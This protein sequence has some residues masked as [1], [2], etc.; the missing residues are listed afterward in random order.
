M[1]GIDRGGACQAAPLQTCSQAAEAAINLTD[2]PMRKAVLATLAASAVLAAAMAPAAAQ[3]ERIGVRAGDIM[4]RGRLLGVFPL[5]TDSDISV[6]GGSVDA[7]NTATPELDFTYF[8]TDNIAF[9]LI[10]ATTI[11]HI[12]ARDVPGAGDISV[13]N[14]FLLPPSLTA[15]WHFSP[16]SRIDP[17]VGAGINYTFFYGAT[18]AGNPVYNVTYDNNVGA[19]VQAGVNYNF[20]GPWFL[21]FDVK[22]IFLS[23][24]AHI[25]D[26][27]IEANVDLNPLIIGAGIGVRF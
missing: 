16:H 20:D 12:T 15:Q 21:N 9:E 26:G 3:E 23:T 4:I 25:N 22:Q 8:V 19:V 17:Y 13:G 1:K 14:V 10:A 2:T 7:S 5:T 24:T 11:H 27:Q 6:I 18:A